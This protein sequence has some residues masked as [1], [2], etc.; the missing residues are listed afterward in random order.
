MRLLK[1]AVAETARL[2]LRGRSPVVLVTLVLAPA[3]GVVVPAV[4]LVGWLW[5]G[6]PPY[7]VHPET[8][9]SVRGLESYQDF[10][11]FRDTA[12]TIDLAAYSVGLASL[13]APPNALSI[14]LQCNTPNYWALLGVRPVAGRFFS[15][16][17]IRA[18]GTDLAVISQGLA[19]RQ[20]GREE[21]ALGE[22]VAIRG[23]IYSIIG[24]APADFAGTSWQPV[25]VWIPL[26]ADYDRCSEF[27]RQL[28][29]G[30][31]SFA[32][33]I[34]GRLRPSF[35]SASAASEI[36]A[37][38]TD[39]RR[40]P[41]VSV[42]PIAESGRSILRRD[43]TVLWWLVGGAC[44]ALLIACLNAVAFF[45][46]ATMSRRHEHAVRMVLGASPL[47]L[48]APLLGEAAGAAIA[49]VA[50]AWLASRGTMLVIGSFFPLP[51]AHVVSSG[52]LPWGL[53]VALTLMACAASAVIP[54]FSL[55]RADLIPF[56][57]G[58]CRWTERVGRM[59]RAAVIAQVATA[60]ALLVVAALFWRSVVNLEQAVGYNIDQ[61]IVLTVDPHRSV[62]YGDA[63]VQALRRDL[64][65]S[66]S[67]HPD[68]VSAALASHGPFDTSPH[69]KVF[70]RIDQASKPLSTTLNFVSPGYFSA[71]GLR[72]LH[73]RDLLPSDG[74]GA[75]PVVVLSEDAA[76]EVLGGT[77]VVGQCVYVGACRQCS[78]IVGVAAGTHSRIITRLVPEAF[79]PLD[80]QSFYQIPIVGRAILV[81]CKDPRRSKVVLG[82]VAQAAAPGVPVAIERPGELADPQ[83]R[84]WRL[85]V[86]AFGLVGASTI[87]LA[88]IGMHASLRIVVRRRVPE[89]GVRMALGA[90]RGQIAWWV[91]LQA[92]RWLSIGWCA[93]TILAV[94]L[95]RALRSMLCGIDGVD[96]SSFLA[97]SGLLVPAG[98]FATVHSAWF[99]ARV[100]PG[101]CLKAE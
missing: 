34:I 96:V 27:G 38:Q 78:R 67:Q 13:G 92:A 87:A 65:R 6:S 100:D 62:Y 11:R 57:G 19:R 17:E 76:K 37:A 55:V 51:V 52:V 79:V 98:L 8:V 33:D 5:F 73:G 82:T 101:Q 89:I 20:F 25:D 49:S 16:Q 44:V 88:L 71:T 36:T 39:S 10:M 1:A 75:S 3:L 28:Q 81:M 91:S 68:V 14:R 58:S 86:A 93:G 85:G 69:V 32:V 48:V 66:L 35:T 61:M 30:S 2:L 21:R 97:A 74:P 80:Q 59:R 23:T 50:L 46:I 45:S 40:Q 12:A 99:A 64:Q 63:D 42:V 77:D 70:V 83:T 60:F 94:I 24:I 26:V 4:S 41:P 22:T 15:D 43:G 31:M 72:L 90:S 7:V 47:Q 56:L 53:L 84:S 29:L 54:A 18:S 95:S 9:V